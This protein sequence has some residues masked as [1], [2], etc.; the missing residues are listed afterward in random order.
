[1]YAGD[2]S[3][4]KELSGSLIQDE[5]DYFLAYIPLA[6]AALAD[7]DPRSAQTV[8]EQMSTLSQRA[9]S[10]S[11]TGAADVALL[12]GDYD[13]AVELLSSGI[14]ADAEFGNSQGV[15]HKLVYLAH[16][17]AAMGEKSVAFATLEEALKEAEDVSHL[18]P[19]ALL[20]ARLGRI[21]Q[22]EAI[23]STLGAR[24]QVESRAAADVILGEIAL[25][26]ENPVAAVDAFNR[27]LERIDS[28]LARMGLGRA[29]Y[30]SGFYAEA[31]GEFEQCRDRLGEATALF[32]DDIPTFHH[33]AP[34]YYWLGQ[35]KLSLGMTKQAR[36]DLEQYVS[37]RV[38]SDRSVTTESARS[39]VRKLNGGLEKS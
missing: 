33:A 12:T 1:M 37:L 18:L 15:K 6:M 26:Q 25:A 34:L 4:A 39:E 11:V 23:A 22:A 13:L 2:F 5:P 17:Q 35:T 14:E 28:W 38:D 8:Y 30:A 21:E 10:V 24:L 7:N 16:A 9:R 3:L 31:L 29:Y 19:A 36:A 32:L 20:L 27:S